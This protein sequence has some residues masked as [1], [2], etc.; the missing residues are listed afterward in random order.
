ML[1]SPWVRRVVA[2]SLAVAALAL[3]LHAQ[4]AGRDAA[5]LAAE[6]WKAVE[7]RRY[8][9][10]YDAFMAA[11]KQAPKEPT[12][13]LGAGFSAWMLGRADDAEDWLERALELNPRLS[14]ASELLGELQ[15]R[16][17]RTREA[18]A[19]YEAALKLAPGSTVF[20]SK[21]A[22]WGKAGQLQ[23]R[24]Y[25][26]RGA[27]FR[28]LFEGPADEATARRSVEMLEAAYW[29]IGGALR[30]Y[31]PRVITVVLYTEQQFQDTTRSPAWSGG[32]YD[33][34]IRV[35]VRNALERAD[36]LERVLAHEFVHAVVAMLAGRTVPQWLNEG[37]ATVYE[38]GGIEEAQAVVA[39]FTG[40]PPL[41]QLEGSFRN[42]PDAAVAVAYAHSALAVRRMI[43]LRSPDG[44]ITLLHVRAGVRETPAFRP[45]R[46]DDVL[47][48]D[49]RAERLSR[50]RAFLGEP[51]REREEEE[52]ERAERCGAQCP[53][54]PAGAVRSARS[55][56]RTE[57]RRR[58]D[59]AGPIGLDRD[60]HRKQIGTQWLAQNSLDSLCQSVKK[61]PSRIR[62]AAIATNRIRALPSSFRTPRD[63]RARSATRPAT[64]AM[65]RAA[66]TSPI[67]EASLD[68]SARSI[69]RRGNE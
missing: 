49:P 60:G 61:P 11:G 43:D 40:R 13:W 50:A 14:Q 18:I 7:E 9:D 58:R 36:E 51:Q 45:G 35:P 65:V 17:G 12:L 10:A 8:A 56:L 52:P 29:R 20:A 34:Q 23:D 38:P 41:S 63:A 54:A 24:F 59:A 1:H 47:R 15:Y 30:T 68:R 62:Y 28:V 4:R 44:V 27:H 3:P 31:P 42:L 55:P 5:T 21:L 57:T 67:V 32:L 2:L 33:G 66:Y 64:Q 26:S 46:N 37:L 6:A 19:T 69:E 53:P 16:A 22:E 39:R 25:E 48:P